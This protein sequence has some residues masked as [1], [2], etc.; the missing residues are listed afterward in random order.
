MNTTTPNSEN[1]AGPIHLHSDLVPRKT[2]Q[3]TVAWYLLVMGFVCILTGGLFFWLYREGKLRYDDFIL[4]GNA[5]GLYFLMVGVSAY[6]IGR[7][8]SHWL[9]IKRRR[10]S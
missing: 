4:N 3:D 1:E 5:L 9:R 8:M 2:W 10:A 6:V 7:V